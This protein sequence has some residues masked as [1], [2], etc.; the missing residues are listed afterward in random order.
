MESPAFVTACLA[1]AY[2]AAGDREAAMANLKELKKMSRDG[3]VLPFNL[4]LVYL[5]LGDHAR[6]LEFFSR[7][8]GGR[9]ADDGVDRSGSHLRSHPVRA[10]FRGAREED[11]DRALL[12]PRTQRV[13][14]PEEQPNLPL[15]L[16]CV[17][18]D[19][20][21]DAGVMTSEAVL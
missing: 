19:A 1:F 7:R 15:V 13:L 4:A 10:A 18:T 21:E 17:R 2:G 6:A 14:P 16:G 9:F 8:P 3:T 12:S 11:G 20:N 5:G